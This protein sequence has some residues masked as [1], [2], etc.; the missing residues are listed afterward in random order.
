MTL[1]RLFFV[2]SLAVASSFAAAQDSS[3]PE[4]AST[5]KT[6][7]TSTAVVSNDPRVRGAHA[8]AENGCQQCHTIRN[9]GGKKGP[10]LSGVGRRLN[11]TQIRTQIMSGGKQMPPFADI[12][13]LTETDDLVAYLHS[14]RD[15]EKKSK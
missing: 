7:D 10:D 9:N 5:K 3:E 4:G 2:L 14:L 13:Q 11:E 8:F 6:A 15:K 1:L 12:L